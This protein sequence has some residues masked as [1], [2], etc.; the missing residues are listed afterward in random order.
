VRILYHHRTQ[1][2]GAEGNH[3]VSIVTALRALGHE[4][5]VLSPPG[6]D[7]F[8]PHTTLPIDEQRS[9]ASGWSSLWKTL[10]QHMPKWLFEVAEILFN[11]PAYLRVRAA[12]KQRKYDLL[13]ERYATYMIA[14]ALAARAAG[15]QFVL[16]VNDVSGVA[17][18]VRPQL[19]PRLCAWVER[20]LIARCDLA[21]AV[22]SY[23]GDRLL[24]IGLPRDRLVVAPNGFQLERVRL[25]QDRDAMRRRYGL[26]DSLVLGFAGW[27]VGWDR[28]DF[29][30]EV[31]ARAHERHPQ[32]KLC[33]VGDGKPM[34]AIRDTIRGTAL[35]SM[36]VH[37][38][39]VPRNEVYDHI[40]MFDIGILP[41]SNLFGSPII[42]FEMMGLKIPLA[43]PRQPPM[44]YVQRD[45]RTALL[46]DPLDLQSCVQQVL[47]LV[48][49]AELRR[50]LADRAF[51]KL[52]A[53]HTW[54]RTAE[55]IL[56][57]LHATRVGLHASLERQS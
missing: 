2:R 43:A 8:D 33:L 50:S 49:N 39:A 48:E 36:V 28:L 26:Q 52:V 7:P 37:T 42:M 31:F 13:F 9:R 35:E 41:H 15:C 25:S 51:Q 4:V 19:F 54:N 46:F 5:D 32:L 11:V 21:H 57:G 34:Q 1:G 30:I 45:G 20:R 56:S 14:G 18:R 53:E 12:L 16:E 29:L 22:S 47:H 40:Q 3:I 55:R 38:G 6:V 23:L 44:Q 10:S 24:E 27:F 17:D